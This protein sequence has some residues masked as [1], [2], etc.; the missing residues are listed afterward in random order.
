MT[1]KIKYSLVAAILATSLNAND[2][3]ASAVVYSA[4]K[5]EQSIQDVTSD[6]EVIT[7]AELEERHVIS[8]IDALRLSGI[9]L[10]QSGGLGQ[11][12][13]FFMNGLSAEHTLVM[14]DGIRYNDPTV[15]NGYALLDQIM[16]ANI[17]RIE[18]VNGAQ[19]GIWGADAAA[20]IINIITKKSSQ[21]LEASKIARLGVV[22][23]K[24]TQYSIPILK[25]LGIWEYFE[26]IVGRQ[27]VQNPKPHPEPIFTALKLLNAKGDE[28]VFMIGDTIMDLEAAQKANVQGVG[29]LCG[30]G[31]KEQMISFT[32]LI[33][34]TAIDAVNA[35]KI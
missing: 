31:K 10:T 11:S 34:D 25:T 1:N 32:D 7:G 33:F 8:V 26:T 18:I 2:Q 6:V 23:T 13:S 3:F 14:I 24:T 22:T 16:V 12:S 35:L 20:G 15:T 17:D 30:Y 5:S 21:E 28:K 4:T 27:E 29:V 9:S 19:S